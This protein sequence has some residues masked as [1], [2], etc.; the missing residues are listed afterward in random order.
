M[1]LNPASAGMSKEELSVSQG[2]VVDVRDVAKAHVLATSS[3]AVSNERIA[4]APETFSWQAV[5]MC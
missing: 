1:V 3:T 4:I 2:A 5:C